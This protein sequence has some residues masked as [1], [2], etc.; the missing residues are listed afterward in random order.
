[1]NT[2]ATSGTLEQLL[3]ETELSRITGRSVASLR[4]DR[5]LRRGI[6]FVKLGRLVKYSPADVRA[7]IEKNRHAPAMEVA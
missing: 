5:L 6:P 3:D 4:R 2:T 1:M 7:V